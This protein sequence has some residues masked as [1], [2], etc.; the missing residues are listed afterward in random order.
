MS[1]W[2]RLPGGR[3]VSI[4]EELRELL[5]ATTATIDGVTVG[6]GDAVRP[7]ID[8]VSAEFRDRWSGLLPSEI[9]PLQEAR[10]LYRSVGIPPTRIRPSSE[11][12][13][14]RVLKGLDLYAINNAVDACNLASL[15]FLLPVGLYDLGKVRGDVVLRLGVAGEEYPGIRKGP[16]HLEGRLGLFDDD[17]PFGSPTSDSARTC[18]DEGTT[19]LLAVVMATAAYPEADLIRHA[20]LLSSCLSG[21]CHGDETSLAWLGSSAFSPPAGAAS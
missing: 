5:S 11:A 17:G 19:S 15:S 16:V 20:G 1:L 8:R 3:R 21:F 6:P 14:R 18:V 9:E 13:L 12:L 4:A 10:R 7:D 2:T